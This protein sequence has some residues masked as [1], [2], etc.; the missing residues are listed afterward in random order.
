M[1]AQEH[2]SHVKNWYLLDVLPSYIYIIR[3]CDKQSLCFYV[4]EKTKQN[5]M[6]EE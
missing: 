1:A 2:N 6:E 3:L 5:K 4:A